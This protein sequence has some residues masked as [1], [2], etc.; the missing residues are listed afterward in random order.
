MTTSRKNSVSSQI[1]G[2]API[3]SGTLAYL[4]E[5]AR[6]NYYDF[7]LSKFR[8]AE[9]NGLTKSA[10]AK[11]IGKT[12]DRIGHLL[13]APGNWTIDTVTEL[14][15]GIAR[16]ENLPNS[17]SFAGRASRNHDQLAMIEIEQAGQKSLWRDSSNSGTAASAVVTL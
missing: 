13:G 5:R 9:K 2:S 10:I 15:V 12:P 4:C 11:R 14:L 1:E 17:A 6:N 8:E 3:P 16:E 7:V